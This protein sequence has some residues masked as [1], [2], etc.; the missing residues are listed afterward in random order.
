MAALGGDDPDA[1]A[2]W[3]TDVGETRDRG[4]AV[5]VDGLEAGLTNV[6]VIVPG[7]LSLAVGP[8][9]ALGETHRE[10]HRASGAAIA[11]GCS[12]ARDPH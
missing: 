12:I 4:Y 1:R 6:A 10:T 11:E 5:D 8:V 3:I 7:G 9:R 2:K